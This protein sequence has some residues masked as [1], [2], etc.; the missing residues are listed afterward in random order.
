ME[1]GRRE[2]VGAPHSRPF[3]VCQELASP[4]CFLPSSQHCMSMISKTFSS[5]FAS[6]AIAPRTRWGEFK[7]PDLQ[8]RKLRPGRQGCPAFLV[9]QCQN[10]PGPSPGLMLLGQPHCPAGGRQSG[11][12]PRAPLLR[13]HG[14]SNVGCWAGP[15][16]G[17]AGG[18]ARVL[19]GRRP[20][21]IGTRWRHREPSRASLILP[22]VPATGRGQH[23]AGCRFSQVWGH[24]GGMAFHVVV[25]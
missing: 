12:R 7:W 2:L 20:A 13:G 9:L 17:S 22:G 15:G 8:L 24:P 19:G 23:R 21:L 5:H 14:A 11:R 18:W 6:P 10:T 4:T 1:E 3:P 16:R 25:G